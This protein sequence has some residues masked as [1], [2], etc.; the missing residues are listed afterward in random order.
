[1]ANVACHKNTINAF[2]FNI[3]EEIS[4]RTYLTLPFHNI[5]F[6]I[7]DLSN[8]G[9]WTHGRGSHLNPPNLTRTGI[10]SGPEA[11]LRPRGAMGICLPL[12]QAS[13]WPLEP[14]KPSN[15]N[16]KWHFFAI[17]KDSVAQGSPVR[18][19]YK[20][21]KNATWFLPKKWSTIYQP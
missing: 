18:V 3:S 14:T 10:R 7:T 8:C 20:A 15:D 9:F 2:C 19:L 17:I 13:K 11:I 6:F 5:Y 21:K 1:M 16:R 12:L 4:G